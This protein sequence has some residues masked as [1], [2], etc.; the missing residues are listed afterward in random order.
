VDPWVTPDADGKVADAVKELGP[1]YLKPIFD[2]LGG[3]IPYDQIRIVVA[4]LE[5]QKR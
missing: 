2:R 4:H 3:T 5:I 1:V